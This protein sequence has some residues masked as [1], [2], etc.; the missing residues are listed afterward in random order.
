VTGEQIKIQ[1]E[2]SKPW[3]EGTLMQIALGSLACPLLLLVA[4]R[5]FR[6]R[7]RR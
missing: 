3:Y 7:T 6:R 4:R 1:P 2:P 5:K